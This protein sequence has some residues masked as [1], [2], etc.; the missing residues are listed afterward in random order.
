[1][2]ATTNMKNKEENRA[3][4][5]LEKAKE[6]VASVSAMASQ[7]AAAVG[8][9]ADNLTASAGTGIKQLGDLIGEKAPHEGM[10]GS[11]SQSVAKTLQEGGK[12]LEEA[13]LSGMA[14]D[15]TKL[16]QR[17]PIPAILAGIGVGIGLGL[18]MRRTLRS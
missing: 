9:E 3:T 8:K 13:K 1:M 10:L 12:Y 4:P 15:L 16:I 14:D 18:L 7:A 5:S 11:A 17:N 2:S 6:A